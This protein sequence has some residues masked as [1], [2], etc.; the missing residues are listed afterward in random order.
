MNF[1]ED[2]CLVQH[3]LSATPD[4]FSF[5]IFRLLRKA[6]GWMSQAALE[7]QIKPI[8]GKERQLIEKNKQK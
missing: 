7:R 2:A 4:H 5:P 3:E 8:Y 6:T 1:F